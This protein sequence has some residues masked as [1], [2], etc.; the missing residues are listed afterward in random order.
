MNHPEDEP[1]LRIAGYVPGHAEGSMDPQTAGINWPDI[2]DY[3]PDAPQRRMSAAEARKSAERQAA[4][5]IL[6]PAL[7]LPPSPVSSP[8]ANPDR[9][10]P[11]LLI[12]VL[13]LL[14]V[15][16]TALAVRPLARQDEQQHARIPA[17]APPLIVPSTV[18]P[19]AAVPVEPAPSVVPSAPVSSRP[20]RTTTAPAPP[21]PPSIDAARFELT[22][23]VT[24]LTVRLTS[25]DDA[26]F[27]VSTPDDSGLDVETSFEDD[28]LSVSTTSTGS[29]SG[30]LKVLLSDRIVWHLRMSA[31]VHQATF[32]TSAGTVSRVDLDGGAQQIDVALGRLADTVPI[33]MTGG[34]HTW[35][36][37][38]AAKVPA[39]IRVGSGAGDV[40][41]YGR[42]EG[43]VGAG[44][45]VRSGDLDDRAGLDIDAQAGMH[46]LE[47]SKD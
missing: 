26:N 34:V 39:R 10:R 24:E 1:S 40:A 15:G 2:G 5:R 16:G 12:G 19:T 43:G 22:T 28:V 18:A 9:R 41:V 30:K 37:T 27:R 33:R 21:A 20:A 4:S 25:L 42:H 47:I 7:P 14:I 8:P 17:A 23:G 6:P 44:V 46:S 35:R 11:A 31:G 45:T 29:G 3:W 13:A 38:T 36:I 32:D